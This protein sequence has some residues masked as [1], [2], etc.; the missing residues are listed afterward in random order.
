[1]IAR[2]LNLPGRVFVI[3]VLLSRR[4]PAGDLQWTVATYFLPENILLAPSGTLLRFLLVQQVLLVL[5]LDT[6]TRGYRSLHFTVL[7]AV[8][9]IHPVADLGPGSW[10]VTRDRNG[11]VI[12]SLWAAIASLTQVPRHSCFFTHY[13]NKTSIHKPI[14]KLVCGI[15]RDA[16][17]Q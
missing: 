8:A 2:V 13:A 12:S 10:P 17:Q 16:E 11:C 4:Q 15:M 3:V 9:V 6:W 14:Q 5:F 7:C 1:L